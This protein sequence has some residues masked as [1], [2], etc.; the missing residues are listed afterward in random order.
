ME[1]IV[2]YSNAL[3]WYSPGNLRITVALDEIP[4]ETF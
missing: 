1:E 2:A 4:A 3:S